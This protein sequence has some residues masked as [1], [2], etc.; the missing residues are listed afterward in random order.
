MVS[1][2]PVMWGRKRSLPDRP[3]LGQIRALTVYTAGVCSPQGPIREGLM[4]DLPELV[5]LDGAALIWI[6]AILLVPAIFG[7]MF[8]PGIL[9]IIAGG[10]TAVLLVLLVVYLLFWSNPAHTS[11]T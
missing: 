9:R 6:N 3:G 8:L 11:H 2:S 10:G 1:T 5:S 4:K 7:V